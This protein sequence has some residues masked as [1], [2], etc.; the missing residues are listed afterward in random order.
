MS[1]ATP[2]P[3]AAATAG[4]M[5]WLPTAASAEQEAQR[6]GGAL[7][8]RGAGIP[9]HGGHV[10]HARTRSGGDGNGR[11]H[12]PPARNPPSPPN[13]AVRP[14]SVPALCTTLPTMLKRQLPHIILRFSK[15][16]PPAP[17]PP[18]TTTP[19]YSDGYTTALE[20]SC[21]S[22]SDYE[23]DSASDASGASSAGG[24]P[25]ETDSDPDLMARARPMRAN[26]KARL[27][28]IPNAFDGP[29][30]AEKRNMIKLTSASRPAL[31]AL[32]APALGKRKRPIPKAIGG[33]KGNLQPPAP[34]QMLS[35][36]QGTHVVAV[37]GEHAAPA[38]PELHNAVEK[39]DDKRV[40]RSQDVQ[41]RSDY[42]EWFESS[43]E[44]GGS[45]DF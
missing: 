10:L 36:P 23:S 40:L 14:N 39:K 11:A 9:A 24:D 43:K 41:K 19:E 33:G 22:R 35:L 25:D 37:N 44:E 12:G 8:G 15:H 5:A 18:S 4:D 1:A 20:H 21:S 6:H 38:V 17:P 7:L 31:P 28:S 2:E 13:S 3:T 26:A 27:H 32:P 29:A 34:A 16:P 30:A 45:G 42:E